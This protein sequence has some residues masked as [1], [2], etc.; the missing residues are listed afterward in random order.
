MYVNG[1]HPRA[2]Y[3][4]FH[5]VL[6]GLSEEMTQS[7]FNSVRGITAGPRVDHGLYSLP[8]AGKA[9]SSAAVAS[10]SQDAPASQDPPAGVAAKKPRS[11][12]AMYYRI[13]CKVRFIKCSLHEWCSCDEISR[14]TAAV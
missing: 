3:R 4:G 12:E 2:L 10:A 13:T 11:N 8:A 6:R 1:S 14:T 9:A 7:E 5:S